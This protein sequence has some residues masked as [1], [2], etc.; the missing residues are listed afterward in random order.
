MRYPDDRYD[1]GVNVNLV[2]DSIGAFPDA[3]SM[4]GAFQLSRAERMWVY[5]QLFHSS[6]DSGHHV[7]RKLPE[8]FGGRAFPL[9]LK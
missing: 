2:N 3:I 8:F 1:H 4:L 5:G 7:F 9:N 6:Y